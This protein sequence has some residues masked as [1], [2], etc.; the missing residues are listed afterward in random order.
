MAAEQAL[1]VG[2]R[3]REAREAKGY[4]QR[5]LADKIPG[6][7][8]GTQVSGWERGEH[9]ASDDTLGHI[10]AILG[11]D[12]S[13][14][15]SKPTSPEDEEESPDLMGTIDAAMLVALDRKLDR[16][17]DELAEMRS[18]LVDPTRDVVAQ[19]NGLS[20][21]VRLLAADA[22]PPV[23]PGTPSERGATKVPPPAPAPEKQQAG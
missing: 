11:R 14:F 18:A 9:K 21:A 20:A 4:T 12:L 7:S 22:P 17:L 5:E 23:A 19:I 2:A 15:Y 16:V 13:W 10:A 8:D 1:L 3:I 6:K